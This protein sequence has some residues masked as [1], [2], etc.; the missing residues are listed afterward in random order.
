MI[1]SPFYISLAGVFGLLAVGL[2]GLL[3]SRNLIKMIIALQIMVKAA[4]L[5]IVAAGNLRQQINTAQSLAITV[6][7]ADTIVALLDKRI[8]GLAGQVEMRDVATPG[9]YER[10]TGQWKGSFEG[11]NMNPKTFGMRMSKQLPGLANFLMTGQWVEPGGSI[12]SVAVSGRNAIQI[13]CRKDRKTF[14]ARAS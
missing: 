7:V 14:A 1:Q 12:M 3:A 5:G 10:Y 11:W 2:Y 4:L 9:T 13:I 8:P 6:I